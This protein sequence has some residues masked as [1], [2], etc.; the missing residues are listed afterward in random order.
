[1]LLLILISDCICCMFIQTGNI[2]ATYL[3]H[4]MKFCNK[5]ILEIKKELQE[6]K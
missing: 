3:K 2:Y 6:I 5:K 4:F 1:M